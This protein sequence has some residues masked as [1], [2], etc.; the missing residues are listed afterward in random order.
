VRGTWRRIRSRDIVGWVDLR[1]A[2]FAEVRGSNRTG[3]LASR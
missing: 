1:R 3:G 2:W